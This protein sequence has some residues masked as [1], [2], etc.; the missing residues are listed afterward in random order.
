MMLLFAYANVAC[1]LIWFSVVLK[2]YLTSGEFD[3]YICDAY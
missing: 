2:T 3:A 1:G